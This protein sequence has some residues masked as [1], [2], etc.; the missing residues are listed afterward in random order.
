MAVGDWPAL[1][2]G[3]GGGAD[4]WAER[5]KLAA[6]DPVEITGLARAF[7]KAAGQAQLATELGRQ[8]SQLTAEGYRVGGMS[9]HDIDENVGRTRKLLGDSGENMTRVANILDGISDDLSAR[10]TT[11]R[12]DVQELERRLAAKKQAF[13]EYEGRYQAAVSQPL[14]TPIDMLMLIQQHA[15]EQQ[16]YQDSSVDL[17]KQF[18]TRIADSVGDYDAALGKRVR[19]LADMGYY[20]PEELSEGPGDIGEDPEAGRRAADKLNEAL[21]LPPGRQQLAE[22]DAAS[23]GI[24][25]LNDKV[26]GGGRLSDAE[27]AYMTQFYDTVGAD[28]LAKLPQALRDAAPA[29][30]DPRRGPDGLPMSS[31]QD[32]YES[33]MSPFRD[34]LMNLSAGKT[35]DGQDVR[36]ES[37][38]AAVT[39]LIDGTNLGVIDPGT[40]L[41]WPSQTFLDGGTDPRNPVGSKLDAGITG[42]DRYGALAELT[43]ST[44]APGTATAGHLA[45]AAIRGKQQ[46]NQL[47]DDARWN[48]SFEMGGGTDDA[49]HRLDAL[50]DDSPSSTLLAAAGRNHEASSGL[51]LDDTKRAQVMGLN[52]EDGTGAADVVHSGTERDPSA[53]GGQPAQAEAALKV[54]QEV[55]H[56]R[57]GYLGRMNDQVK[58]SVRDVGLEY[59]DS[60]GREPAA[61]SGYAPGLTDPMGRPVGP[62]FQ[63][64]TE[65]RD[66]YLQFVSGSG[67]GAAAEFHAKAMIASQAQLS[68]AF[69]HGDAKQVT[70]ALQAAGRLD[71]AITQSDY[72]Y[73]LD[74]VHGQDVERQAAYR[75]DQLH[76]KAIAAATTV[77]VSVLG[78]A[79]T[80]ATAGTASPLVGPAVSIGSALINSAVGVATIDDPA[81]TAQL[82]Q[83]RD[84]LFRADAGDAPLRRDI[85]V[86]GA[87]RDAGMFPAGS[88]P[89]ILTYDADGDGT[90]GEPRDITAN[91][92]LRTDL[93]PELVDALNRWEARHRTPDNT[94]DVDLGTYDSARAPFATGTWDGPGSPAQSPWSDDGRA[95]DLI[96]GPRQ[97]HQVDTRPP[98]D[99]RKLDDPGYDRIRDHG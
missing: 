84:D 69:A 90:V 93:N 75:A 97:P 18:G 3:I 87:M 48:L 19:D 61:Q 50:V 57:D 83:T 25:A 28:N 40:G 7:A 14:M 4:P 16:K 80:L 30:A 32:V 65:D 8:G 29:G 15:G 92:Q 60:F 54:V 88:E 96:Y 44:I 27:R 36:Y 22:I 68:D 73:T 52:W 12:N 46:L 91:S 45:D 20:P 42:M 34:S 72:D 43:K 47:Q 2:G 70:E 56:D 79:V 53:G 17:V 64:S 94:Q 11:A 24:A 98:L 78:G 59:F 23:A 99:P 41:R 35:D 9:V 26:R 77:G 55:G 6:G 1:A 71:G 82:P 10:T 62:S 66:H 81:P 5:D 33:A 21:G 58:G 67:D 13:A 74:T 95:R 89:Q 76:H 86:A 85:F 38:P 31:S 39:S 51:L 37:M 49:V 63:L